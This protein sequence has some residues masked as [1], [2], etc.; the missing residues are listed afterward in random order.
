M[1][2]QDNIMYWALPPPAMIKLGR[3]KEEIVN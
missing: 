3:K 1:Q 2:K